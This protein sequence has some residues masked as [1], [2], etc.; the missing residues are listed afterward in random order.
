L[1]NFPGD[2]REYFESVDLSDFDPK[3][4]PANQEDKEL[5]D[6][7]SATGTDQ[8]IQDYID[9]EDDPWVMY[10]VLSATALY[11]GINENRSSADMIKQ[12]QI[13][14][15][16]KNN[17]YLSTRI[18]IN[19]ERNRIWFKANLTNSEFKEEINC[20]ESNTRKNK[21]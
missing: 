21:F 20:L 5:L 15:Y 8:E 4:A 13:H 18:R 9:S 3:S 10:Y 14:Q 6:A 17:N 19:G 12:N 7:S 11:K 16:L 2:F 1:D